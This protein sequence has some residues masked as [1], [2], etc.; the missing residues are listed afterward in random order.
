MGMGVRGREEM[1]K[2]REKEE[3]VKGVGRLKID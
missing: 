3:E 1:E 2:S